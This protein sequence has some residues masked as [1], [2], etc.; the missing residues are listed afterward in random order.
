MI[1]QIREQQAARQT[2]E[3]QSARIS[4]ALR[5]N[6]SS[7]VIGQIREQQAAR[8]QSDRVTS[9]SLRN[10]ATRSVAQI[11]QQQRDTRTNPENISPNFRAAAREAVLWQ[12]GHE[13]VEQTEAAMRR[14][15][16]ILNPMV[17]MEARLA[18]EAREFRAAMELSVRSGHDTVAN[19]RLVTAE[20]DRQQQLLLQQARQQQAGFLGMRRMGFAAQQFGYAIEDAASMYGTMGLSGAFRAAGNNLTAMAAVMGPQVGVAASIAAAVAS[21]GLHWWETKKA[22]DATAKAT[23]RVADL[24]ERIESRY[25]RLMGINRQIRDA[26]T[27]D[28]A[29]L[30]SMYEQNLQQIY[31]INDAEQARLNTAKELAQVSAN[32][33]KMDALDAEEAQKNAQ[34]WK[35][36]FGWASTAWDVASKTARVALVDPFV[37]NFGNGVAENAAAEE[38]QAD[39]A[40]MH[41]MSLMRQEN[42]LKRA[43]SEEKKRLDLINAQSMTLKTD[44]AQIDDR[45][46]SNRSDRGH[47]AKYLESSLFRESGGY[48]VATKTGMKAQVQNFGEHRYARS[49]L[50][51]ARQGT[52]NSTSVETGRDLRVAADTIVDER[53]RLLQLEQQQNLTIEQRLELQKQIAA[54]NNEYLRVQQMAF[55]LE[56]RGKQ[57]YEETNNT[58]MGRFEGLNEELRI[59]NEIVRTRQKLNEE[60]AIAERSGH[61]DADRAAAYRAEMERVFQIEEQNRKAEKEI[62]R[63]KK[64]EAKLERFAAESLA[65]AGVVSGLTRGSD[66]TRKF[67]EQEKMR[68]M[69]QKDSEPVVAE[70]KLLREEMKRQRSILEKNA[71]STPTTAELL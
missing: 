39:A 51:D 43:N 46:L 21:I 41:E 71:T 15:R 60:I 3:E 2:A 6:E 58:L 30:T 50:G 12:R 18:D 35:D 19:A 31:E 62:E 24:T 56:K 45:R 54:A 44:S 9:A 17:E 13:A 23:D 29:A 59:Q 26:R 61:M 69:A 38:K 4:L 48:D 49:Y 27:A 55:D 25:L 64:E 28:H 22:A 68:G 37:D 14:M 63:L 11:R 10:Q 70:L 7:Y 20:F 52:S 36:Y 32:R 16:A 5:Q 57:A 33:A 66:E 1:G 34:W 47:K 67:L 40:H 8:Q 53:N 42:A 65:P